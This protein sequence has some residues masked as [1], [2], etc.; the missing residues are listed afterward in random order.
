MVVVEVE[1]VSPVVYDV[2]AHAS[3]AFGDLHRSSAQEK[4][5]VAH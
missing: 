4:N 1:A 2:T 5:G 3:C